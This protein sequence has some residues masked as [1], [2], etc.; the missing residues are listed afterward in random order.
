MNPRILFVDDEPSVL[1]GLRRALK[2]K[3]AAWTMVFQSDPEQAVRDHAAAPYDIVVTDMAMPKLNGVAMVMEMRKVGH[4]T[5]YIMLTGTADLAVA[6]KAIN[7]AD[8]FRFFTKPC[9]A[10]NLAE[11]IAAG[12]EDLG[13]RG[14]DANT[15]DTQHGDT[16]GLSSAIGLAALNRLA[17]GVIVVGADSRVI[18]TNMAA[19]KLIAARDGLMMSANETLRASTPQDSETLRQLVEAACAGDTNQDTSAL[20]LARDSDERP[21]IALVLPLQDGGR[22]GRAV[23]FVA[24]TQNQPLPTPDA[25]ARLFGVSRA[26]SRLVHA[27]VGGA[28]LNDAAEQCGVTSSTAR[29]YLKQIFEKTGT[30]RQSELVKLVLT[31]PKI[32][33]D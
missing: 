24:D 15:P 6:V 14:F 30:S 3:A 25:I 21:L 8:V 31:S 9:T 32:Y 28:C 5:N 11:G 33:R 7:H 23:V 18:M 1:N 20:A 12:L 2:K 22:G 27:M 26:E 10:E 19:G 13:L 17:L 16:A 29:S 4:A